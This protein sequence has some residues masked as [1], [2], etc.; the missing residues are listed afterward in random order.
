MS[1]IIKRH[2]AHVCDTT[3]VG[4][5]QPRHCNCCK[6][7]ECPLS[8]ECLASSI[9]YRATMSI[10]GI[11]IQMHYIRSTATTFKQRYV[12]RKESFTHEGKANQ[13]ALSRQV[14]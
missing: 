9:V 12:N 14:W 2:N 13:T 10:S 6:P 5:N 7:E 8:R 3:H 1:A 4:V 11:A